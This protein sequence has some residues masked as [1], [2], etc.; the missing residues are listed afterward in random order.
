MPKYA[1][2]TRL[3]REQCLQIDHH[4]ITQHRSGV[5]GQH[6]RG[7]QLEFVLLAAHNHRVTSVVTAIGLDDVIN[8]ATQNVGSFTFA[9]I[10]PLSTHDNDR[11]S[12]HEN[13]HGPMDCRRAGTT[14]LTSECQSGHKPRQV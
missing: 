9:F 14:S 2:A 8:F 10:A 13:S 7:E 6:S 1:A 11:S 12:S 3:H 4:A 5:G